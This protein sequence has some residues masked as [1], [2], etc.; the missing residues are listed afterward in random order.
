MIGIICDDFELLLKKNKA[1]LEELGDNITKLK[2]MSNM[3]NSNFYSSEL[4]ILVSKLDIQLSQFG[5][6]EEK[7]IGYQ[8]T[9]NSVFDGYNE[10]EAQVVRDVSSL[11]S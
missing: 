5:L 3:F 1:I 8:R 9:L 4:K 7:L 10:Q 11:I 2:N 6:V